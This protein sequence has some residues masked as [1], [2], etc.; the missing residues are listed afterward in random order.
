MLF[1]KTTQRPLYSAALKAAS[2]NGL[3][4]VLFL[5]EHTQVTEGAISNVFIEKTGHWSTPPI[6]CG[7]LP[8]VYRR[9]LL[10]TRSDIDERILTI[11]D[12]RDADA[13]YIANAVHGLR[14]VAVDWD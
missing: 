11:S 14:R 6:D 2:A 13:V 4:D 8:G 9:H 12:L 10:E 1:H 7:A 3:V 5:N